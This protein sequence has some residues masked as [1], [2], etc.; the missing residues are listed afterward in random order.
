MLLTAEILRR[1]I[2]APDDE[3]FSVDGNVNKY[4]I[5]GDRATLFNIAITLKT[6]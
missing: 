2:R 4:E 3:D 5:H 1:N 6:N